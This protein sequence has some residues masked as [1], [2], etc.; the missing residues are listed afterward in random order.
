MLGQ[1]GKHDFNF[2]V[3][4][5]S[6]HN[7]IKFYENNSVETLK[8][9]LWTKEFIYHYKENE[10]GWLVYLVS[11]YNVTFTLVYFKHL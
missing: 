1:G 6:I 4:D 5:H 9:E 7:T 11:K 3:L 2:I 8:N 10:M